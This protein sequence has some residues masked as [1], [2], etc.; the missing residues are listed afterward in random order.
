MPLYK[1]D[2]SIFIWGYVSGGGEV[3][4]GPGPVSIVSTPQTITIHT[5]GGVCRYIYMCVCVCVDS[6]RLRQ[7][8]RQ[9]WGGEDK[10]TSQQTVKD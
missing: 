10:E 5:R 9:G 1:D 2:S 3:D 7:R 8:L 4:K 6:L